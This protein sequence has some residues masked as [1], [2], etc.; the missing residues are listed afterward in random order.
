M[1][2]AYAK[3]LLGALVILA[4]LIFVAVFISIYPPLSVLG[5]VLIVWGGYLCYVSSQTV[6]PLK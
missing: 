2:R 4:G 3:G 6:S 5:L 1:F